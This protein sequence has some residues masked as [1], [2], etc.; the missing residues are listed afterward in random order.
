[1]SFVLSP[2]LRL[3]LLMLAFA[4]VCAAGGAV[5]GYVLG[6]KSERSRNLTGNWN[7]EVMS[8]LKH[9]LHPD[10][11]QQQALQKVL[12]EAV[13]SMQSI[14]EQTVHDADEIVKKTIEELRKQMHPDQLA[15]FDELAKK[16]GQTTIDLLKV[17]KH[18][19]KAK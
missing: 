3:S 15:A 1:M 9:H 13:T 6:R 16:R 18:A 4:L 10:E 7:Q 12:D 17:E 11:Q 2:R 19:K 5:V 14:R 8:A